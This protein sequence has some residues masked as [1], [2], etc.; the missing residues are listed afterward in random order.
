MCLAGEEETD[1]Q[2]DGHKEVTCKAVAIG[3]GSSDVF[4]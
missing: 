2:G 1:A 3:E 4:D